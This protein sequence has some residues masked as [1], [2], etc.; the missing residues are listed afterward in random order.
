MGTGVMRGCSLKPLFCECLVLLVWALIF[1]T[2]SVGLRG[3]Y[4]GTM[5]LLGNGDWLC[6]VGSSSSGRTPLGSQIVFDKVGD[7]LVKKKH[8]LDPH[9]WFWDRSQVQPIYAV[10]PSLVCAAQWIS[11]RANTG[12]GS[13]PPCPHVRGYSR[14]CLERGYWVMSCTMSNQPQMAVATADKKQGPNLHFRWFTYCHV[15]VE[16]R[17]WCACELRHPEAGRLLRLGTGLRVLPGMVLYVDAALQSLQNSFIFSL[18][19]SPQ[20]SLWPPPVLQSVQ[21]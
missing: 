18:V 2:K 12:H 17:D 21:T 9:Q 13:P 16:P 1:F 4:P 20:A 15:P 10:A 5:M 14:G 7:C 11:A 8:I 19:H 6:L 3:G